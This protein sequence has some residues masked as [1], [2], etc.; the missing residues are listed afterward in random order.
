[1]QPQPNRC[2]RCGGSNF[3]PG[4]IQSS[5]RVLFRPDNMK[6]WTVK[7]GVP[8]DVQVCRDCGNVQMTVDTR[9]IAQLA[10]RE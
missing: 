9:E 5:G 6:F 1:M 7:A 3:E 4:S 2:L 8:V 10:R